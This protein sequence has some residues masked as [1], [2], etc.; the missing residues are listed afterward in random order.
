MA[1]LGE[2]LG[3]YHPVP[4]SLEQTDR[5]IADL[6]DSLTGQADAMNS[7]MEAMYDG[8]RFAA[9]GH[10]EKSKRFAAAYA[11]GVDVMQDRLAEECEFNP[12][13]R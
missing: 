11:D 13:K 6:G 10:I 5:A 3:N 2:A 9:L 8:N 12:E 1:E 7:A 4:E